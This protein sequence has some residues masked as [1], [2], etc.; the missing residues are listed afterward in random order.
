MRSVGSYHLKTGS[1]LFSNASFNASIKSTSFQAQNLS[2]F[3]FIPFIYS[4]LLI[5]NLT[6]NEQTHARS[7]A[8][9]DR[10]VHLRMQLARKTT[11]VEGTI[12][13]FPKERQVS[14]LF[15]AH[16]E[17]SVQPHTSITVVINAIIFFEIQAGTN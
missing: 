9:F 11:E 10:K 4:K 5:N 8:P 17:R 14:F 13:F 2:S 1:D 6:Y 7:K 12:Q 3:N 15:P 16:G